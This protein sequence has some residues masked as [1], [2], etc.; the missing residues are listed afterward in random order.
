MPIINYDRKE[1]QFKVVYYGPALCG[2]TA[3]LMHL[4][5]Q[6]TLDSKGGKVS[7]ATAADCTLYFDFLPLDTLAIEGF[8]TRF[9]L[10]PA[11]GQIIY[12][13]TRQLI[14][15]GVDGL[16]FVADSQW[17][18]MEENVES[19]RG[20]EENLLKQ[21]TSLDEIPYVL[22]YNKRDLS[23]V[24]PFK[25]MEY[26]LNHRAVRVPSFESSAATGQ[27][28]F[29]TL[30]AISHRLL[31]RFTASQPSA[32]PWDVQPAWEPGARARADVPVLCAA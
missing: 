17:E 11:P 8:R 13:A 1:I 16:V 20:L 25:Y 4:H 30:N 21:N 3:N 9:Q 27:N 24:A 7:L 28:V 26:A 18:K 23:H 15:R 10:Y 31:S 2:K 6:A 5:S 32:S 22:Q 19:F 14:L 29:A 12:N